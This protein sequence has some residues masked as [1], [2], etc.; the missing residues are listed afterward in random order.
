MARALIVVD[1]QNDF[2]EGGSLAVAGGADVLVAP[3]RAE[4]FCL[5]ALEAMGCG[6]PVIHNGEGPTGEFVPADGGW[7]L[8]AQ[9][10]AMRPRGDIELVG[11]GYVHEVDHDALVAAL[12]KARGIFDAG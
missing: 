5:P 9:R 4:G 6:L 11:D 8:P 2:C 1:V 7:A 10:V 3:Y 12:V